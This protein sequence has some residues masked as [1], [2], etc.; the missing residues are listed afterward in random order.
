MH[1]QLIG[2]D[3]SYRSRGCERD[4][5]SDVPYY[6]RQ[7]AAKFQLLNLKSRI[8]SPFISIH[9]MRLDPKCNSLVVIEGW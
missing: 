1:K 5:L 3:E 7:E 6:R 2:L 8:C 9:E 4:V